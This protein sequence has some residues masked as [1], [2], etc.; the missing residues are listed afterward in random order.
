[1]LQ[2]PTFFDPDADGVVGTPDTTRGL[3]LLGLD[4]K[5][6]KYAAYALHSIFSYPTS[7]KWIPSLDTTLPIHV[8][9]MGATRWGKNW[10]NFERLDW[11]DDV[12]IDDVRFHV[13]SVIA[14]LTR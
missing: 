4:E 6:A 9:K 10:G 13:F 11:V 12:D 7:E 3:V 1:M 8:A 2:T 5:T 14:K